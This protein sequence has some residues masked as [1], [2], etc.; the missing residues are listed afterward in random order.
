MTLRC[1]KAR[2]FEELLS[3]D[4]RQIALLEKRLYN[5]AMMLIVSDTL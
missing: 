2:S 1:Q 3:R 5:Y 4:G